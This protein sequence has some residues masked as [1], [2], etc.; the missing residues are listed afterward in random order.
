MLHVRAD[1]RT[2]HLR[3]RWYAQPSGRN[4]RER[5]KRE[6]IRDHGNFEVKV[7]DLFSSEH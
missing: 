6:Q 2:D 4:E 7:T 1:V 3:R 5:R